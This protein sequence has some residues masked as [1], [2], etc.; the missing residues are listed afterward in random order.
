MNEGGVRWVVDQQLAVHS[1]RRSYPQSYSGT[2]DDFI[3]NP[4][5]LV[6]AVDAQIRPLGQV[7]T[8]QSIAAPSLH[9]DAW[10]CLDSPR[11]QGGCMV[12]ISTHDRFPRSLPEASASGG[13]TDYRQ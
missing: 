3:G 9:F 5:E 12:Q 4:I 7:L 10:V 2:I 1:Q 13:N 8:H 11:L 6:L